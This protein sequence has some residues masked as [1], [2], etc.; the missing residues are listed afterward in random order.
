MVEANLKVTSQSQ[1]AKAVLNE[2]G[3]NVNLCYHT[4]ARLCGCAHRVRH[5][6][7]GVRKRSILR[8]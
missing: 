1:L 6:Q 5:A 2:S 7:R 4:R 3:Q 8:K